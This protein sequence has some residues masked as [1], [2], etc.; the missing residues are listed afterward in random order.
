MAVRFSTPDKQCIVQQAYHVGDLDEAIGRWHRMLGIGPFLVRRHIALDDVLYRGQ[1]AT[2]DISAAHAQAGDI[3]IEL[4]QQHCSS[5]SA[6]RDMF[7]PDEEGLHHIALFPE[8]HEAMVGHYRQL[9]FE[10]AT[11]LITAERRG[12][13]YVDTCATLGHMVEIYRV[14]DSLV[15]FYRAIERAAN[16]W[17]RRA[18]MIE[19]GR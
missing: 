11:E 8:D 13:A 19:L 14:N 4:V 6:F 3:Q 2:L 7:A 10:T 17:D 16:E 18:L 5:P 1:R 15:E 9:G 12:A